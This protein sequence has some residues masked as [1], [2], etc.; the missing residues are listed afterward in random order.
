MDSSRTLSFGTGMGTI[1]SIRRISGFDGR[2]Q[3][4]LGSIW[5]CWHVTCRSIQSVSSTRLQ[6]RIGSCI[7]C[8][9]LTLRSF[10]IVYSVRSLSGP[11]STMSLPV[12]IPVQDPRKPEKEE[13]HDHWGF[14]NT[15]TIAIGWAL[16]LICSCVMLSS[17]PFRVYLP[18]YPLHQVLKKTMLGT[19]T[20][21]GTETTTMTT[22]EV[23]KKTSWMDFFKEPM[24]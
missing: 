4:I 2:N 11:D 19:R 22:K 14:I 15:R 5:W 12:A 13:Q 10:T 3:V 24:I 6:S 8:T 18:G 7:S 16:L 23:Q 9:S 17:A 1:R 21:Q 20:I